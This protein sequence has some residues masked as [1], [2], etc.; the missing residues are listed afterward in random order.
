MLTG[1][2]HV[3]TSLSRQWLYATVEGNHFLM[4]LNHRISFSACST[5][6]LIISPATSDIFTF[7]KLQGILNFRCS[8]PS[9]QICRLVL[10][11]GFWLHGVWVLIF[12]LELLPT[13]GETSSSARMLTVI[14]SLNGSSYVICK[15]MAITHW[16][17]TLAI[18]STRANSNSVIS[19][20]VM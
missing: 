15:L 5:H 19:I 6:S 3:Y 16:A 18:V 12:A 13:H 2:A 10:P 20:N 14:G 7:F 11:A 1:C 9:F 17:R 8:S 4:L